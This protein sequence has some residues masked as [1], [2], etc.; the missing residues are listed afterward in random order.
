MFHV[1]LPAS[2]SISARA[3]IANAFAPRKA[4]LTHLAECDDTRH[5]AQ[6]LDT[7][8]TQS[9]CNIY[10]GDGATSLRFF[11][12]AAA[13]MPGKEVTVRGS[14][15][16]MS[17]PSE[18]LASALRQ[19]GADITTTADGFRIRGGRLSGGEARVDTS[20]SSQFVSALMLAAPEWEK[21]VTLRF[22]ERPVSYPYIEMTARVMATFGAS[23]EIEAG[24][25]RV[26]P[27]GYHAPERYTVEADWSA[28]SY[29]YELAAVCR[30]RVI[31]VWSL[32]PPA[33]SLQ[34]DSACARLFALLGVRTV[35][36]P[37]GS[38]TLDGSGEAPRSLHADMADTPDLVPAF[39]ASCC[40]SGTAFEISGIG[41]LRH[42]E[43]DRLAALAAELGR[44]G[45]NVEAGT[46]TLCYDGGKPSFPSGKSVI[47]SHGDHRMA[48]SLAPLGLIMPG[49]LTTDR[50]EVVEKSFPGYWEIL[51]RF[52]I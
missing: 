28:A 3:L 44:C 8:A 26:A 22:G 10:I 5:L 23:V 31:R 24:G 46:D 52:G 14:R 18:A 7:L 16:L 17:R 30:S 36:N 47:D 27:G 2:K 9:S 43:S 38:A 20:I 50:P 13:S 34:G 15:Q 11:M 35:F 4:T 37:D 32:T 19:L 41:H 33:E 25:V 48:M 40:A 42:K 29:M 6:A 51:R 45:F 1:T 49:D 21:G 39:A 12:A